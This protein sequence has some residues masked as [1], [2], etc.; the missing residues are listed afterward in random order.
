MTKYEPCVV[1]S[2]GTSDRK[3]PER[4]PIKKLKKNA[5]EKSIGTV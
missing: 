1:T 3:I 4:P 2:L 5:S